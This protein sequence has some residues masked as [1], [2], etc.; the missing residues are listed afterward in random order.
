MSW[1][2]NAFLTSWRDEVNR[3][4]PHRGKQSDGTIGDYAH[5]KTPSEHNPDRNGSVDAWD[6]D[7]NL[8]GSKVET[9]TAAE[10][11]AMRQL[12]R[13]FQKQPGAQLWIFRRQI[14]NRD[15]GNWKVRPYT[16]P[17][18]HD[19]HCHFQSRDSREGT[20]VL[21]NFLDTVFPATNKEPDV[22]LTAKNL[23]DI[24][25]AVWKAKP[26]RSATPI[27]VAAALQEL[28]GARDDLDEAEVAKAVLAGLDPK[29]IADAVIAALPQDQ[30]KAVVNELS[31]RLT[32]TGS[33]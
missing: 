5:S 30:A 15:V 16:G 7:V 8:F 13:E 33:A 6:C 2:L 21:T 26:W 3:H 28:H 29:K 1:Y 4:F 11:A 17:S 22:D 14:A 19:H 20:R 25:G 9:G 18:P 12:I 10:V 27:S 31:V 24:A 23:D 32:R